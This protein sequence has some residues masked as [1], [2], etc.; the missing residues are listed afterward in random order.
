MWNAQSS[1]SSFPSA[2]V[3]TN[4]TNS[5][6]LNVP[7][8]SHGNLYPKP[9]L[10]AMANACGRAC[11]DPRAE[12]TRATRTGDVT[13]REL[14]RASGRARALPHGTRRRSA[15]PA[16]LACA[17]SPRSLAAALLRLLRADRAKCR[18]RLPLTLA[19]HLARSI[20]VSERNPCAGSLR[21]RAPN[22]PRE[23]NRPALSPYDPS[24]SKPS[25]RER[26]PLP[27]SRRRAVVVPCARSRHALFCNRT[28]AQ[29]RAGRPRSAKAK[30]LFTGWWVM[31]R[32]VVLSFFSIVNF[33]GLGSFS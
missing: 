7:M 31:W 11:A 2:T 29:K 14:D 6:Y 13:S 12:T 17:R 24:L 19:S 33:S 5:R 16:R 25:M 8:S 26:F 21:T 32:R 20:H 22:E 18:D 15:R 10:S 27:G 28:L 9:G 1:P 3:A 23:R 4:G 30:M